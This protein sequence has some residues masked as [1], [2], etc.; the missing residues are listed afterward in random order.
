MVRSDYS[1]QIPY[2]MDTEDDLP[3]LPNLEDGLGVGSKAF[4][5]EDSKQYMLNSVGEWVEIQ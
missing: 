2:V 3:N 4:C 1:K 5:I